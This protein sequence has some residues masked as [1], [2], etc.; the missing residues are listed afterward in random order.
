MLDVPT[1]ISAAAGTLLIEYTGTG[2]DHLGGAV[3]FGDVNGDGTPDLAIGADGASSARVK[4]PSRACL[5]DL[6]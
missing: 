3:A 5:R 1:H 6:D 2:N 4:S